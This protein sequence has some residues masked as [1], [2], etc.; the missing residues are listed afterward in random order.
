M[1]LGQWPTETFGELCTIFN[2]NSIPAKVKKEKYTINQDGIPYIGTKDVGFDTTISYQTG[3]VIPSED[4]ASFRLAPANCTFVCAEGGSA[5][6]K[7]GFT[8]KK[9]FFGNKL[10]AIVPGPKMDSKFIFYYCLSASFQEQFKSRMSGMIG[11]VNQKKFKTIEIPVPLL[12]EQQRIVSI[13]DEA[14]ENI[15]NRN[16]QV[17][18]KLNDIRTLFQISLDGAFVNDD[19]NRATLEEILSVQPRNGWSPPAAHHSDSGTPVLTLSSVTGNIFRADQYKFTSAPVDSQRHYWVKNGDFLITRSNTPEL[20]GHVA[21]AS[22]ITT[23]TI[24]SDLIMR[25]NPDNEK[26][27]TK[28]LYYQMRTTSLRKEITGRAKGANPTMVKINKGSIQT[29]PISFP[30]LGQQQ[31]II[32]NIEELSQF[33]QKLELTYH[34]EL[35]ALTELKQSILQEAFSGELQEES[36]RDKRN[37]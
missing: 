7:I 36:S 9:V 8:Q 14:F 16:E 24:Y 23:P 22:D 21:I 12:E 29:I 26:V 4:F 15:E 34:Q 6:R 10:Y 20:V 27:L 37:E 31:I 17:K 11:G 30:P 35:S 19:W 13:V 32:D 28:F 18:S 3:V 33:T 25:M 2:G 5:G 1:M